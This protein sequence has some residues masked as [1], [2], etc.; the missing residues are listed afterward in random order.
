MS[1]A[2]KTTRIGTK[3]STYHK[4][5]KLKSYIRSETQRHKSRTWY[6]LGVD[7]NRTLFR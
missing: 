3:P 4:K 6:M 5:C 2:Q 1:Q 7:S